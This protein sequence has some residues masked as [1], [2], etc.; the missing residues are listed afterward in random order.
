MFRIWWNDAI[1]LVFGVRFPLPNHRSVAMLEPFWILRETR[2]RPI[3][4][5][6]NVSALPAS[7]RFPR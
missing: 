7:R 6:L 3:H 4:H 2:A 1:A 5:A